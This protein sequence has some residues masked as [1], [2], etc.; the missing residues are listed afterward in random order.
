M[1]VRTDRSSQRR[2]ELRRLDVCRAMRR[3]SP[4]APSGLVARGRRRRPLGVVA[5]VI[6]LFGGATSCL[7]SDTRPAPGSLTL[8]VTSDD[9]H[10]LETTDGWSIAI[11]RLLIGIGN[12][13]LR[14][15]IG[16]ASLRRC[17]PYSD[18]F[19]GRLLD[20]RLSTDQKL[21]VIYG[22]GQCYFDFSTLFPHSDTL[23]GE[24]VSEADREMMRGPTERPTGPPGRGFAV[25]L[26]ATAT[27][28]TVVKRMHWMFGQTTPYFNCAWTTSAS[29]S[30]LDL[31][32]DQHITLHIVP[33]PEA[34][35]YDDIGVNAALR[36]DLFAD[37]DT[38][39]NADDEITLDELGAIS[40][41][42]ARRSGLYS[43]PERLPSPPRSFEDYLNLVLLRNLVGFREAIACE[44]IPAYGPRRVDAGP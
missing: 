7:P 43:L 28:G 39:G 40:L 41:D 44:T 27:R 12:A 19:Y 4:A 8:V 26:A 32:S 42:V 35:F 29:R 20:G 18:T 30:D 33:R 3:P 11:D 2:P 13:S 6:G 9:Q 38:A 36:F 14:T 5:I 25:A 17:T 1:P 16:N 37:A 31:Q 21:S 10:A 23:L 34:L 24:G 15:G 22:L